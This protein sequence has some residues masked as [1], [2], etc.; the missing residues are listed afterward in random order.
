MCDDVDERR[1]CRRTS[2]DRGQR[3]AGLRIASASCALGRCADRAVD[4]A[5]VPFAFAAD[6]LAAL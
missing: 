2:E 3:R 1:Q 4:L 6:A 5:A